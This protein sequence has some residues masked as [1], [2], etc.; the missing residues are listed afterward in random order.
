MRVWEFNDIRAMPADMV[1]EQDFIMRL[2]RLHR[3]GDQYIIY[4]IVFEAEAAL[5]SDRTLREDVQ[6]KLEE[7]SKNL[8]GVYAPMSNGD[9]FLVF[10]SVSGSKAFGSWRGYKQN[11]S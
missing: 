6:K 8:G 11:H 3:Q 2:R 7:H 4:N 9:A 1:H 5:Q 10:P